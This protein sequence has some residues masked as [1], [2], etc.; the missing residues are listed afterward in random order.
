[1][2]DK[3]ILLTSET[4][5]SWKDIYTPSRPYTVH[6]LFTS[7]YSGKQKMDLNSPCPLIPGTA[8]QILEIKVDVRNCAVFF[9][10]G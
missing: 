2:Y 6:S 7:Y 4:L 1:V 5:L 8:Y 9:S 3:N 10:C